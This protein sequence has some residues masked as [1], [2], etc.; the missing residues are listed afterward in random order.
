M[1]DEPESVRIKGADLPVPARRL[2]GVSE[3]GRSAAGLDSVGRQWELA[4]HGR[5]GP[6]D[7]RRG[8]CRRS[9]RAAGCREKPARR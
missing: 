3:H 9:G 2:L 7:H 6:I 4:R 1:L 8:R 5:V